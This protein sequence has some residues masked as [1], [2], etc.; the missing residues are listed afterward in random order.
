M[1]YKNIK[2]ETEN[3]IV[4]L[5][6]DMPKKLNILTKDL[7]VELQDYLN[8]LKKS[9][10]GLRGLILTG[11]LSKAFS[12]GGDIKLMRSLDQ[13]G[14]EFFSALAQNVTVLFESLD[15]PVIACVAGLALGG[16]CELAMSADFIYATEASVFGQPETK[17]GLIP[18]FGGN[19]RLPLFVGSALAK[20]LIYTG[21]LIDAQEAQRIGLVNKLFESREELING[22]KLTIDEISKNSKFAVGQAKKTINKVKDMPKEQALNFEQKMYAGMFEHQEKIEGINAFIEK[23]PPNW[24]K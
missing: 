24:P 12:A 16:G 19:V 15:I 20:E 8:N 11:S 17:I 23:R 14:A 22:A 21:R 3:C 13:K 9:S 6:L 10:H 18:G 5:T 7:L 1:K 4:I 2:I